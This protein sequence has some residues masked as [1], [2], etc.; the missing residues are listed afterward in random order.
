[1]RIEI[2][3][4]STKKELY[5]YLVTNKSQLIAQKKSL[6][7][8][9]CPS[10]T[11]PK[12]VDNKGVETKSNQPVVENV[13]ELDVRIVC[14]TAN[15]MDSH[16]DVLLPDGAKKSI[17]ERKMMI[18]HLHDHIHRLDAKVGVTQD[19]KL[20]DLSFDELG[21]SGFGSGTA[22]AVVMYSRV[23]RSLNAEI[24]QQYKDG[25]VN[26]HS[27]GLIYVKIR[28]A[29]NDEDYKSE[30]EAWETY[31][32]QIINKEL[33]D[34]KGYFWA[35]P[36]WKMIEN[37]AVLFG[38]NEITP[39][40]D[41]NLQKVEPLKSTQKEPLENTPEPPKAKKKQFLTNIINQI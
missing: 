26:Q 3:E 24:F 37:S 20:E 25:L 15:W 21:I 31:Y 7:I 35:V 5:N 13:D 9:W 38:S 39:T 32:D 28:L 4:F 10:F 23:K 12:I 27:V 29:I 22:Q 14:N 36:E 40:L 33:A 16:S 34:S 11:Q 41:N 2:P 30:F 1:M 17:D 8:V 19:I 6:P 18:P